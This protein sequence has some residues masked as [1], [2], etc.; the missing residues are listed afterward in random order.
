MLE[1]QFFSLSNFMRSNT[2]V[3]RQHNWI[4]P[5]LAFT[6]GCC[7]VDVWRLPHFIEVKMKSEYTNP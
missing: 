5:E 7:N 3:S 6:T 1:D 4:Q 2:A